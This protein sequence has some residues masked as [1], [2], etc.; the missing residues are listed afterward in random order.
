MARN[1]YTVRGNRTF[2]I[3]SLHT[4][5]GKPV[6]NEDDAFWAAG[7]IAFQWGES[8]TLLHNDKPFAQVLP[9]KGF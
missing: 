7:E 3:A 4:E 8:C 9:D 5:D 1:D 6:D 2:T